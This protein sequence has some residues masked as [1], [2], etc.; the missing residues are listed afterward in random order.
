[1]VVTRDF[2]VRLVMT[3]IDQHPLWKLQIL[4]PAGDQLLQAPLCKAGVILAADNR[5][6]GAFSKKSRS[7]ELSIQHKVTEADA[8]LHILILASTDELDR[9]KQCDLCFRWLYA[10]RR[11]KEFCSA[12]CRKRKYSGSSRFKEYRKQYMRKRRSSDKSSTKRTSSR[13]RVKTR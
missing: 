13:R 3:G 8:V 2:E 11:H 7:A 5:S 9:L 6:P 12:E 4:T 10:D 1:V